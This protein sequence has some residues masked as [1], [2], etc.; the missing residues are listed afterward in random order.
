MDGWPTPRPCATDRHQSC[1]PPTSPPSTG[2]N[3]FEHFLAGLK[4]GRRIS[5]ATA[6]S[7]SR[8]FL[9]TTPP[10][11]TTVATGHYD[12][13]SRPDGHRYSGL[14]GG[15]RATSCM[16]PAADRSPKRCSRSARLEK[17]RSAQDHEARPGHRQEEDSTRYLLYRRRRFSFLKQPPA[18]ATGRDQDYRLIEVIGRHHDTMPTIS[19]VKDLGVA[20]RDRR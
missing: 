7:S 19:P 17:A 9:T 15:T 12:A 18:R 13:P 8:A 3:V 1:T 20:A 11:P 16:P 5:C 6:K 14:D 2:T 10:A 4:A